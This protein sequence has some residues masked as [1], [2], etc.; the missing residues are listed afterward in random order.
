VAIRKERLKKKGWRRAQ[1]L[2]SDRLGLSLNSAIA[3][4][5]T[6]SVKQENINKVPPENKWHSRLG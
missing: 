2:E 6:P 4:S 5:V 3:I 1:V